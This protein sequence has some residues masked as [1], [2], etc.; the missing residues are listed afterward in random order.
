MLLLHQWLQHAAIPIAGFWL[1]WRKHTVTV[2]Q[3]G[4]LMCRGSAGEQSVEQHE[5]ERFHDRLIAE[6][7][8]RCCATNGYDR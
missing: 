7:Y 2:W 4:S 8:E 1:Y 3:Q 6:A 5:F